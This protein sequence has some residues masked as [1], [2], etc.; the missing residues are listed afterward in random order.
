VNR[1]LS[2]AFFGLLTP[3][4][5]P[6]LVDQIGVDPFDIYFFEDVPEARHA[7]GGECTTQQDVLEQGMDLGRHLAQIGRDIRPEG[8]GSRPVSPT[9]ATPATKRTAPPSRPAVSRSRSSS[10]PT[11][12]S[13]GSSCCRSAGSSS[14]RSAGSIVRAASPKTSRRQPNPRWPGCASPSLSFSCEGLQGRPLNPPEFR[15][16]L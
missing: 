7:P 14:A 3:K 1:T 13:K 15:V 16:R 5:L 12:K 10:G 9:A 11:S 8:R 6:A 4:R 2:G